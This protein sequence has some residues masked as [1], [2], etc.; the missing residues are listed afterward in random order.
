MSKYQKTGL[1][2][3]RDLPVA[4]RD[5]G[6]SIAA[7]TRWCGPV[8]LIAHAI[9]HFLG[10]QRAGGLIIL[11]HISHVLDRLLVRDYVLIG[12]AAR[13]VFR[14]EAHVVLPLDIRQRRQPETDG[15]VFGIVQ[16]KTSMYMDL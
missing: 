7:L 6:L 3:C 4:L 8:V 16:P 11:V 2:R 12:T 5:A 10:T 9:P 13:S 14:V 15:D 1:E